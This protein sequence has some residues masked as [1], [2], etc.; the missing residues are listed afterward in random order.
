MITTRHLVTA[1]VICLAVLLLAGCATS[2]EEWSGNM[3]N[4]T[5]RHVKPYDENQPGDGSQSVL[6]VVPLRAMTMQCS[7]LDRNA[8]C[9]PPA[10]I[11]RLAAPDRY[12]VP[13]APRASRIRML[14]VPQ[15]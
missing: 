7:A 9:F 6:P 15:G 10:F 2:F 4:E 1:G 14:R 3:S 13:R 8:Q 11:P 12:S 5:G